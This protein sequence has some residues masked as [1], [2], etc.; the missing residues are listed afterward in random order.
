[1]GNPIG[2]RDFIQKAMVARRELAGE[3]KQ[4]FWYWS[5][6]T[7]PLPAGSYIIYTDYVV[8]EGKRLILEYAIVSSDV[9]NLLQGFLLLDFDGVT[10]YRAIQTWFNAQAM[11]LFRYPFGA[12]HE[13]RFGL[14]QN[15]T[16]ANRKFRVVVHGY[17]EPE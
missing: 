6:E 14:E 12:G 15:D 13:V 5:G 9:L 7:A 1:V 4:E 8:P 11:L 3:V 2:L 17:V 16:T 10:L